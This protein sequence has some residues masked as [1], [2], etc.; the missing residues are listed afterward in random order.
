MAA[1]FDKIYHT[2]INE[3]QYKH[4][5]TN[6][7]K[8]KAILNRIYHTSIKELQY[9]QNKTNHNRPVSIFNGIYHT[10]VSEI[11]WEPL[12]SSQGITNKLHTIKKKWGE[13]YEE[14]NFDHLSTKYTQQIHNKRYA[15][16][17]QRW[18]GVGDF[19]I[20]F[21]KCDQCCTYNNAM[22]C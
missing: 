13:T 21:R 11:K 16:T 2:W 12:L 17:P 8:I 6:H 15:T 7:T 5:E 9:K 19:A 20:L 3:L 4:N 1:I 18:R 22:K 14:N 10:W